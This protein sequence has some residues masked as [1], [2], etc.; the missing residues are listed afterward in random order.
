MMLRHAEILTHFKDTLEDTLQRRIEANAPVSPSRPAIPAGPKSPLSPA[1]PKGPT[2]PVAPIWPDSP[3]TPVAPVLP[4][5]P[6]APVLP[7]D[8]ETE[9]DPAPLT[10]TSFYSYTITASCFNILTYT[11]TKIHIFV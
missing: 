8:P 10:S 7:P 3:A 4:T 1:G 9:R 11:K 5:V 6:V 2:T